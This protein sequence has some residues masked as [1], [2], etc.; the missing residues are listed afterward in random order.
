MRVKS[1]EMD[2]APVNL[3]GAV[4]I[5]EVRSLLKEWIQ[6]SPGRIL[7]EAQIFSHIFM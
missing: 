7:L 1:I 6:S 4:T 3:C 5:A 2:T